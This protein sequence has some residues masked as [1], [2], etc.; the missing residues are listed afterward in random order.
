MKSPDVDEIRRMAP[1]TI[2]RNLLIV[3]V[4]SIIVSIYSFCVCR[5]DN[6]EEQFKDIMDSHNSTVYENDNEEL[7]KDAPNN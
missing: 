5:L 1:L 7:P 3:V 4:I 6:H 2:N